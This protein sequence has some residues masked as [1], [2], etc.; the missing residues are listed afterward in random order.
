[1]KQT[2]LILSIVIYSLS[3][4]ADNDELQQLIADANEKYST[5]DYAAS[6][7]LYSRVIEEGYESPELYYNLG[8][9]YFKNNKIANAILYFEKAKLL[10]PK[11]EKIDH[12]LRFAQQFVVDEIE[13]VPQFFLL[14]FFKKFAKIFK[15][16]TWAIISL[17][18]FVM[19]LVSVLVMFF[20]R[21]LNR[22]R[23]ALLIS[24]LFFVS[25]IFSFGMAT[26]M[27]DFTTGDN[28]GIIMSVVT[29]KSSPDD[30]S[31]DLFL[32][33]EGIKIDITD[34]IDGWYEIRLADGRV[35][36]IKS[37]YLGLI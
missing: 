36:W 37:E 3:V 35:G 24:I 19:T 18:F 10:A 1:M 15:T 7:E 5:G 30:A 33:H 6:I 22:K 14:S 20:N 8:N 12:N 2:L 13:E 11:D 25:S 28:S 27:N 26:K 31:T 29:I 17:G 23:L 32:L 34:N 9:S 16:D 4:F 21:M